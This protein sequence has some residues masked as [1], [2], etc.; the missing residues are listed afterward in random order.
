MI[1]S[2]CHIDI[3]VFDDRRTPLLARARAA[4]VEGF[5]VPGVDRMGWRGIIELARRERGVYAAPG[6][7][8]MYLDLHR[9]KHLDELKALVAGGEVVAIGEIGLDYHVEG[10]DRHRQQE[11][12]ESQL[13]LAALAR[14]PVLLHVRKAHDQVLATLRRQHFAH[15]G[16][17]HAF[18]GSMQQAEQFFEMGFL[19]SICGTVT[20]DRARKVRH[21]AASLPL[22]A[23]AVETDAPDIPLAGRRGADNLPEYLPEVVQ[24][25][26]ALRGESVATIARA[27]RDNVALVL[28]ISSRPHAGSG[29]LLDWPFQQRRV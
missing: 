14:L 22:E 4:G 21:I 20:Y 29:P 11:L 5:I 18:T 1:D 3:S 24:T 12:F 10:L 6:L 19:I 17:V 28:G 2:H 27:T 25:L 15:G 9:G 23:L 8:P 16:I 7:H 26:A 13:R